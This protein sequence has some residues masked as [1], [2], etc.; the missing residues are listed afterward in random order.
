[1][2]DYLTEYKMLPLEIPIEFLKETFNNDIVLKPAEKE[3]IYC[4]TIMSEINSTEKGILIT[5]FGVCKNIKVWKKC[6]SNCNIEYWH[7]EMQSG[8]FNFDNQLFVSLDLLDWLRNA[9]QE[10]TAI[11]REISMLEK[12][13]KVSIDKDKVIKA[14]FKFISLTDISSSFKC[15]LCGYHPTILTFDVNR[16][17]V[18]N[19]SDIKGNDDTNV[20][21]CVN[22]DR[23]WSN[24]ER[25]CIYD[26]FGDGY[27]NA[28]I[29]T[30][31]FWSP[32]IPART[33][34]NSIQ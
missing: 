31:D 30:L 18:F 26:S 34:G 25:S 28:V 21:E 29:P 8:I 10:H 22:I 17:C 6:C 23:F 3:C 14:F 19:I 20:K 13:Y 16:K 5:R 12:R 7:N 15:C 11:S 33:R 2:A 9:V 1:M 24:A 4:T 32:W 27:A